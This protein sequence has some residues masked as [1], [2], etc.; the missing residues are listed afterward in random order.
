MEGE[1]CVVAEKE[2]RAGLGWR[3]MEPQPEEWRAACL[4]SRNV[5]EVED[6]AEFGLL[7]SAC[8]TRDPGQSDSS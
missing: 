2:T 1:G 4:G 5:Q 6:G 8:C 3:D 7:C